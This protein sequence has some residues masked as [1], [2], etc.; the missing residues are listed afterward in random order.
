MSDDFMFDDDDQDLLNACDMA[1]EEA[2][3]DQDLLNASDM[4]EESISSN[5]A[6]TKHI[7]TLQKYFGHSCFKDLQWN[8]ISN[9][10]GDDGKGQKNDHCVVMATGY[11]KSLVYQFPPLFLGKTALVVSPLISLM[12]DQVLFGIINYLDYL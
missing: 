5:K 7:S 1:E 12:E 9:L 6:S 11:G 10:I 8:I 3:D 4:A 2:G